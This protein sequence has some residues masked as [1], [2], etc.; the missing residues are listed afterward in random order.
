MVTYTYTSICQYLPIVR[1]WAADVAFHYNNKHVSSH[2][3]SDYLIIHQICFI[4]VLN[5]YVPKGARAR[6][7]P[8]VKLLPHPN[9]PLHLEACISVYQ[10]P[11]WTLFYICI[12]YRPQKMKLNF[13]I[14]LL[15]IYYYKA[16]I[17]I[18]TD[19]V[20]VS[21]VVSVARAV[22]LLGTHLFLKKIFTN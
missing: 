9:S 6:R 19:F 12:V 5:T 16:L 13:A 2:S 22:F 14:I 11:E 20:I 10:K 18:N 8:A 17:R 3:F 15:L 7:V 4:Q 1:F 21:L